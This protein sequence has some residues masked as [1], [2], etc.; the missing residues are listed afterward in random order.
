MRLV[1]GSGWLPGLPG[2]RRLVPGTG[3]LAGPLPAWHWAPRWR[4]APPFPVAGVSLSQCRG[5]GSGGLP[6]VQ[7]GSFH[8]P[9]WA[10]SGGS[11]GGGVRR[12]EAGPVLLSRP[13]GVWQSSRGPPGLSGTSSGQILQ[14]KTEV[15]TPPVLQPPPHLH[16]HSHRSPAPFWAP[17]YLPIRLPHLRYT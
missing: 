6:G 17:Q 15:R 16:P 5:A 13:Q 10:L 2:Q 4:P 8:L 9:S 7:A 1:R 11:G 3:H 14:G 12:A